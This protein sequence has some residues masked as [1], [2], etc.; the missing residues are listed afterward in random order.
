MGFNF[1]IGNAKIEISKED[2]DI[3]LCI[4]EIEHPDAPDFCEYVRK[5]NVRSPSY[6]GWHDF[7]VEAKIEELFYGIE[8]Q[9]GNCSENFHRETC[10]IADHPGIA[11]LTE[12]DFEYIKAARVFRES[13][14]GG[15]EPGFW[16]DDNKD[17]GKDHVL[18][19]LI[20]LEWWF[21]WALD[22]CEYPCISN[23]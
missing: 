5:G 16:D 15:K 12:K 6:T 19:R 13:T 3:S 22:N 8:G 9:E 23:S 20:W 10:L 21:R 4:D 18:A 1:T 14:N 7:C 2:S 17:N 11:L